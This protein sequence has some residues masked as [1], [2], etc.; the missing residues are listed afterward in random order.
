MRWDFG[1]PFKPNSPLAEK[2]NSCLRFALRVPN[3]IIQIYFILKSINFIKGG[4]HGFLNNQSSMFPIFIAHGPAFKKDFKIESFF[5]VDIYPLMCY[6]LG[7][8]PANMNGKLE[9]VL[10]MVNY[11]EIEVGFSFGK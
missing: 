11:H 2:I 5:S 8:N 9:N 10:K 6:I 1:N 4:D 3:S 7:V